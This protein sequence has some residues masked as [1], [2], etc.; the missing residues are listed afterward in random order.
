MAGLGPLMSDTRDATGATGPQQYLFCNGRCSRCNWVYVHVVP[1]KVVVKVQDVSRADSFCSNFR[2]FVLA[3]SHLF[4]VFLLVAWAFTITVRRVQRFVHWATTWA[5]ATELRVKNH[6]WID[7]RWKSSP[8]VNP[9]I[10]VHWTATNMFCIEICLHLYGS[11]GCGTLSVSPWSYIPRYKPNPLTADASVF[12][13][14]EWRDSEVLKYISHILANRNVFRLYLHVST[15]PDSNLCFKNPS[16][17]REFSF[18]ILSWCLRVSLV[19][20]LEQ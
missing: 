17:S 19:Y 5:T 10:H 13:G 15:T 18:W 2:L 14:R 4:S 16:V 6:H 1:T 8:C 7:I 11:V 20:L 12:A 9:C 3:F